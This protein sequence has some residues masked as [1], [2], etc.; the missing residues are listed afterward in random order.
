VAAESGLDFV[1]RNGATGRFYLPETMHGGVAFLDFDN[2]SYLDVYLIQSGALPPQPS[3]EPNGN[4]LFRNRGDGSFEDITQAA[5]VGDKSHGVGVAVADYDRDGWVDIY[6]TNLGANRLY[7]NNGPDAGGQVT[8]SDV[9]EEAGVGDPAYSTSATFLDFDKDGDLDLWVTN[10][11][12]WRTG[13]EHRCVGR[14]GLPDYCA[15]GTYEPVPDTLYRNDGEGANGIVAFTDVSESAGLLENP[16][17]GLGV[18]AADFDGDGY[19]DVYVA[20]DQLPNQMWINTGDGRFVD[21][22]L[23]RGSALNEFGRA[24]A[25]MGVTAADVDADGDWD[26]FSVHLSGES[27]TLYRNEGDFFRDATVESG[28]GF[29]SVPYTGFGTSFFDFD[30]DGLL[31]LFIA[32]G[33]VNRGEDLEPDF[34]EPNQLLRGLPGGTFAAVT[35]AGAALELLEVSRGAA[36]GDYDND[37]DLDILVGNN[38][39]PVR[40][41]RNELTERRHWLQVQL[42]GQPRFDR[43]AVG[44]EVIVESNG[45]RQRRMVQPGFSYCSSSDP[46]VHFGL[47]EAGSTVRLTVIWP[48]GER[49]ILENVAADQRLEIAAPKPGS[50]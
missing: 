12:D 13:L 7:R 47:G 44:A 22:A 32:N 15:P 26:L 43:D 24:E 4:R 18:V 46:R 11:V 17:S 21:E 20:N 45:R 41:L 29:A 10:Y 27:N 6:V 39:G 1:H 37:G 19:V 50:R 25:G 48:D 34:R 8:F 23:Q 42:D 14:N 31:D 38:G 40:L 36:F 5:G 28:L 49:Q 33:R 2:D 30:H 16:A 3:K 35:G 9:T